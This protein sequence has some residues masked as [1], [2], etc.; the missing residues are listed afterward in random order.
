MTYPKPTVDS[1]GKERSRDLLG[2]P[3]TSGFNF[4]VRLITTAL[5]LACSV[6]PLRAEVTLAPVFSDHM[7]IQ[8]GVTLPVWGTAAPGETVIVTCAGREARTVANAAGSWR[9][10]LRPIPFSG[11]RVELIVNGSNRIEVHD[12]LPGDVWIAAGEGDM[13]APLDD[14]PVGKRAAA[15]PDPGTRFYVRDASGKGRWVVASWATSPSLPAVPFFFARDL[16]ASRKTPIGMIDCT[17]ALPAPI[18]SWI[19]TPGLAGLSPLNRPGE[20]AGTPP[21]R[22]FRSLIRPLA[23]FA[24]TGV[25]WDQGVSDEGAHALRH[26]LF[27]THLIRDWR[28]VWEQGPFPFLMLL[29]SG[30]GSSDESAVEAY[31]G[32]RWN[33]RRAWPWIREGMLA[34]LRLPNTGVASATD[35][36]GDGGAGFDPLVAG[37]RLALAAR[38]MVYGEEIAATGPVFRTA[39]TERNRMRLFFDGAKGGLTLGGAPA[40]GEGEDFAVNSSLKGFALRG[41]DGRWF[42]AKARIDGETIL[43]SSDAVPN[44]V[45]ARYGWK[46][47]PDGNLYDRSGLPALPFRT[48]YDQPWAQKA[49]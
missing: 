4:A 19:S 31:L 28:R 22:L 43:L 48:D 30:N 34:A 3:A 32:E 44:P 41:N 8:R 38:R 40:S 21:S 12:V 16:R 39:R 35:L 14:T 10:I 15:I 2:V 18:D 24:I 49:K 1:R 42:P 9:V 23:P 20:A 29:P 7:V 46:S 27:L 17:T 13:A 45:A 36:G 47:L 25:I 11:D 33:P 5:F 6:F 37:R 26:R